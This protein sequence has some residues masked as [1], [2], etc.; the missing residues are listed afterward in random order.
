M[1]QPGTFSIKLPLFEGPFDLLLFFI[2]RNELDIYDIPI[3]QIIEDFLAYLH[4]LEQL[5]IEIASEFIVVAATLMRIKAK[6]LLPKPENDTPAEDPRREL[7]DYLLEYRKY[8]SVIEE[9]SALE[10]A[11]AQRYKRGNILAELSYISGLNAIEIEMQHVD[12][13]KLLRIFEQVM[14]RYELNRQEIKHT[15]IPFPY[16]VA[17]QKEFLLEILKNVPQISFEQL[18]TQFRNKMEAICTFLAILEL[19]Q[20]N[21]IEIELQEGYNNFWVRAI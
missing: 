6:M 7:V 19:L 8:K 13:Y 5:D 1:A 12:L 2:E 16:T 3:N 10:E 17:E 14:A 15:I 9:L 4:Q 11:Q 18:L 20:N 21:L